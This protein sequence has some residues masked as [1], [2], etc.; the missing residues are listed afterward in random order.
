M[1]GW[2]FSR[3][4]SLFWMLLTTTSQH[5]Q[6]GFWHRCLTANIPPIAALNCSDDAGST[7]LT[8]TH[9]T[10]T[11]HHACRLRDLQLSVHVL[12]R[13]LWKT[14]EVVMFETFNLHPIEI[15]N[16]SLRRASSDVWSERKMQKLMSW[17]KAN[18]SLHGQFSHLLT[19][20]W[21]LLVACSVCHKQTRPII[22]LLTC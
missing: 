2:K 16:R 1:R 17:F 18:W 7:G 20:Q 3:G 10:H 4:Q 8:L 6:S 14:F 12:L 5:H 15:T 9:T 13:G 21:L 19:M 11:I 22:K